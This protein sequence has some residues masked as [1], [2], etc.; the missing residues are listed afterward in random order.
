MTFVGVVPGPGR[1]P[2]GVGVGVRLPLIAP[3]GAAV[4]AHR[5]PRTQHVWL[6][7]SRTVGRSVLDDVLSQARQTGVTV[8][9]VGDSD[10]E[11]LDV[12]AEVAGLLAEH[13]RRGG[14]RRRV[15]ELLTGLSGHPYT[16]GQLGTPGDLSVSYL[17]APV[18]DADGFAVYELQ[19]GPLRAAVSPTERERYIDEITAAAGRLSAR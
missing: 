19:I 14:L 15:F 9:G 12:L 11:V 13:P 16:A 8:F 10:P 6:E 1:V 4:I 7:S 5:D 3:T 2:A 18:F 17:S